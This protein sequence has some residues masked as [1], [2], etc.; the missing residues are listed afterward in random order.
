MKVFRGASF[1]P[2]FRDLERLANKIHHVG[3]APVSNG[4]SFIS[5]TDQRKD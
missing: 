2:S 4:S 3:V 1:H 5:V